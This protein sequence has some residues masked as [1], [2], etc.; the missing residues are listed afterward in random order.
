MRTIR[1]V[2]GDAL[3]NTANWLCYSRLLGAGAIAAYNLR[4]KHPRN[5]KSTT[6][7]GLIY[8]TDKLDG[9]FARKAAKKLKRPPTNAGKTL[10][11][12][13]DKAAHYLIAGSH[14]YDARNNNENKF[15]LSLLGALSVQICRDAIINRKRFQVDRASELTGSPIHI[16]STPSS[17]RKMMIIAGADMATQSPLSEYR[18]GRFLIGLAH[19]TGTI[20]SLTSGKE[21]ID[22]INGELTIAANQ[23]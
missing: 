14:I 21:I 11:Q 12:S 8:A 23:S 13:I 3:Q 20:M 5:T 1:E 2:Y 6:V 9:I 17:K 22:Q 19:V 16:G 15:S 10:D 18:S 7:M 4:G